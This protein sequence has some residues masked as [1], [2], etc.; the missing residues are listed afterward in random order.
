[1]ENDNIIPFRKRTRRKNKPAEPVPVQRPPTRLEA[2]GGQIQSRYMAQMD[3]IRRQSIQN[4]SRQ[5]YDA[6]GVRPIK[7]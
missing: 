2:I 3:T 6:W 4:L 5:P 1:M 7:K